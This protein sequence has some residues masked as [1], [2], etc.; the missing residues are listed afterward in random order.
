[1]KNTLNK[2]ELG[3]V[4]QTGA[5]VYDVLE[6]TVSVN[7]KVDLFAKELDEIAK[8]SRLRKHPSRYM[9]YAAADNRVERWLIIILRLWV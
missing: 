9:E 7:L 6:Q 4:S 2:G 3:F 1:M 5:G 8:L